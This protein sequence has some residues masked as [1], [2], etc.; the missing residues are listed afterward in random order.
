MNNY[1]SLLELLE[2]DKDSMLTFENHLNK[3]CEKTS[4]KTNAYARVSP[5]MASENRRTIM[6]LLPDAN[7]CSFNVQ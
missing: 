5:Y 4:Q 2:T 7:L 1:L 3:I 6:L